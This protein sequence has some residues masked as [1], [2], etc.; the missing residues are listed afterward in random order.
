MLDGK[1]VGRVGAL[2]LALGV[3]FAIVPTSLAVPDAQLSIP[4]HVDVAAVQAPPGRPVSAEAAPQLSMRVVSLVPS[5]M[6]DSR[7]P[8]APA[9]MAAVAEA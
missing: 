3:G 4:R 6:A 5:A 8:V 1:A 2:A 9:A 7:E